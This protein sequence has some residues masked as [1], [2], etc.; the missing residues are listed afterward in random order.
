MDSNNI[1]NMTQQNQQSGATPQVAPNPAVN[2]QVQQGQPVPQGQPVSQGQPVPTHNAPSVNVQAN[3]P[4]N[5]MT[6]VE[7]SNLHEIRQQEGKYFIGNFGGKE[8]Y[9]C[10]DLNAFA[11][12]EE[13]FGSMEEAQNRLQSGSMKDIRLVMWLGLIWDETVADPETGEPI[14]YNISVFQVGSW[15]NTSNLNDVVT[16]LQ[17][18]MTGALPDDVTK[19]EAQEKAQEGNGPVSNQVV[20][21]N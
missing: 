18:A 9:I 4:V 14:K 1:V 19:K 12:L 21:P 17:A 7:V 10:F 6:P 3:A 16:K 5:N 2:Q 13:R 8:R 15:L 20:N 11:E